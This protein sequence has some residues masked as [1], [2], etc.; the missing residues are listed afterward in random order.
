METNIVRKVAAEMMNTS[1]QDITAEYIHGWATRLGDAATAKDSLQ[2]GNAAKMREALRE[3]A[4][5]L[6]VCE[7]TNVSMA[8]TLATIAEVVKAALAE[9]PRN[10]DIGTAEEQAE[11]FEAYCDSHTN[12]AYCPL[13]GQQCVLAWSQMP[14][15][16]GDNDE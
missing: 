8:A 1:M 3:V 6:N 2:V 10:C 12:C 16:K 14:Y 9:P 4:V 13:K 11:R 5:L 15:E 7:K